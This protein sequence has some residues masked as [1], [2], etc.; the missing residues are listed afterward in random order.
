MAKCSPVSATA[1]LLLHFLVVDAVKQNAPTTDCSAKDVEV[2]LRKWFANARDRGEG[3][4]KR[5]AVA[6]ND[7]GAADC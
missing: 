3:S 2:Q 4:Q 5:Q 7:D 1:D 6:Q